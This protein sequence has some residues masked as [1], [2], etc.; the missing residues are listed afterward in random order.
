MEDRFYRGF[1]AGAIGGIVSIALSYISYFLGITA[2]RLS[3]WASILMYA[4]EPP[5]GLGEQLFSV[6]IY[7]GWCGAV[8][9][10][11][12]YFLLLVNSR[13][14]L[15]KAWILGTTPYFVVYV[16]TSLFQTKGTVPLPL[17][18]V[19][20]NYISSSVFSIV[21]GYS[22]RR[23]EQA[24]RQCQSPVELLACPAAKPATEDSDQHRSDA[25]EGVRR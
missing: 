5:F 8:G 17:A 2:L 3:D 4:H 24:M 21:M 23:Q 19:L 6:F 18:T 1:V 20:S 13:H 16:L 7:I 15:L 25:D 14:I 10:L 12:A 11:F 9:S 22:F